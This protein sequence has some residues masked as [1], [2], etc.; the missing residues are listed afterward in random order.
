MK[1]RKA[2]LMVGAVWLLCTGC[3][4]IEYHPYDTRVTGERGINAANAARIER[5]CAGRRRIR[6]A[7]I[8]DTQRRYDET[9]D[10]VRALN[11][12]GDIDFVLHGGDLSDFGATKEF[13]WQRDILNG[14]RMPYVCL[15]GNHDCLGTGEEVFGEV[16][17]DPDFAFTAGSVRFV[18]LNTCAIEFDYSH[19][20]PDLDF[21]D[22]EYE[23]LGPAVEHTVFA[24]HVRPGIMEFN[25]NVFKV[26]QYYTNRFP[27]LGFCLCGHEHRLF[28]EDIYGDG[29][30]YYGCAD[31]G[32]R[33]YLL[34]TIDEEGYACEE[35]AF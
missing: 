21:I 35:V 19:P 8:S 16:F 29:V 9:R 7:M 14:L 1:K 4:L 34:F 33:V 20:V 12:R 27:G 18:C 13:L 6:F 25:N 31:I 32:K 10:A 15:I 22:R 30:I 17:G 3:D 11:A 23:T 24:M 26:F 5:H 2:W 28:R